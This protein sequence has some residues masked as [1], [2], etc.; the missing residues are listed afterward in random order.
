MYGSPRLGVVKVIFVS[1][2]PRAGK[3]CLV[4]LMARE[5]MCQ[6]PHHI[7]LVPGIED[8]RPPLRLVPPPDQSDL[9]SWQC[10]T[11]CADRSF[12]AIA[13][14]LQRLRMTPSREIVLLEAD[15]DPA[16]RYAYP[17]DRRVF[18]MPSP[19][20]VH[21][22]FRTPEQ[23]AIALKKVME[24]TAS[25]AAEIFGLFGEDPMGDSGGVLAIRDSPAGSW[26]EIAGERLEVDETQ[27]RNFL[28]SPIG[29]EIAS[30][31][32][33]Q[34]EYHGL[35]ESDVILINTGVGASSGV[36]DEVARR[37]ELLLSR[38]RA[39]AQNDGLL[40]C[41]DPCEPRDPRRVKLFDKLSLMNHALVS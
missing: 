5:A 24:D 41:C 21:D 13:E 11:Y 6:K 36:V 26:S 40:F 20:D 18:V 14:P 1:G 27:L 37:L 29:A 22:V 39:R 19:A 23:A 32:Q 17:Y 3:T 4:N 8:E 2:P 38:I 35:V 33:L 16:L 34:P 9:A 10:V 31:I 28:D 7:R 15:G 30:R 12:E 25:F